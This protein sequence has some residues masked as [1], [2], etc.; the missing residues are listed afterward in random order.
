[1][2]SQKRDGVRVVRRPSS[3]RRFLTHEISAAAFASA[4]YSVS[5]DERETVFCLDERQEM[6]LDPRY[7][8]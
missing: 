3:W 7:N 8:I 5:V 1:M 6:M 4:L 2:L